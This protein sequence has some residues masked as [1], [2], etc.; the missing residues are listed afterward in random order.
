MIAAGGDARLGGD[1]WD[2]ALLAWLAGGRRGG[3]QAG[4]GPGAAFAKAAAAAAADARCVPAAAPG[5]PR[6]LRLAL[7]AWVVVAAHL[8]PRCWSA[9]ARGQPRRARPAQAAEVAKPR[10]RRQAVP[11]DPACTRVA[12]NGCQQE[13]LSLVPC[14]CQAVSARTPRGDPAAMARLAEAAEAAKRALSGAECAPVALAVLEGG[15]ALRADVTRAEFEGLTAPLRARLWPPLEA[16]GRQAFVEWAGRRGCRWQ[17]GMEPCLGVC[18]RVPGSV[19]QG[20]EAPTLDM[21]PAD[22]VGAAPGQ[23]DG[24]RARGAA[25]PGAGA[26]RG[27]RRRRA[28]RRRERAGRPAWPGRRRRRQRP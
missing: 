14:A 18:L 22:R 20:P 8:Q 16:I 6:S 27:R 5:A 26:R 21:R 23:A 17:G 1:D 28:R 4:G 10:R 11:A 25:R 3:A 2:R 12:N 9:H 15:P 19:A 7:P 24:V 13:L